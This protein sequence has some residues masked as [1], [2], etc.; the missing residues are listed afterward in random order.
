MSCS[1]SS[2]TVRRRLCLALAAWPLAGVPLARAQARPDAQSPAQALAGL[3]RW[4]SG[5]FRRFGFLIYEATLWAAQTGLL[6]PPLALALTYRRAIAGQDIA[7]ASVEQMR[8][9]NGDEAQLARWGEQL[10]RVFPD[11]EPGDR[12]LGLQLPDRA[13]FFHNDR[14]L[15]EV[16][17]AAFGASF[18]AIWL[19]ERTSAPA[20]RAA[21][22]RP[23]GG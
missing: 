22:L 5:E 15:G 23:P 2:R 1:S 21:L 6:R 7:Q 13:R 18:F 20:L 19:D 11:V 17:G 4:G 14:A 12:I 3:R 9:F 8:R 10:T 16:E